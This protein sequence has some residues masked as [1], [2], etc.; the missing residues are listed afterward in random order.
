MAVKLE[1]EALT[2]VALRGH[3]GAEGEEGRRTGTALRCRCTCRRSTARWWTTRRG[4][5]SRPTRSS[6]SC[7]CRLYPDAHD[8]RGRDHR[9]RRA[10]WRDRN[11]ARLGCGGARRWRCGMT[12]YSVTGQGTPRAAARAR[13]TLEIPPSSRCSTRKRRCTTSSTRVGRARGRAGLGRAGERRLARRLARDPA[14]ARG[15]ASGR[16]SRSS[17]ARNFGQHRP[18]SRASI[19]RGRYVITLDADLQN[20]PSEIPRLVAELRNGTTS[21]APCAT[22]ARTRGC[23]SRSRRW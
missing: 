1:V 3:R 23:A 15:G 7:R 12:P 16:W 10:G 20:P 6:A 18:C 14:R 11:A 21:S 8:R 5:R 13:A 4:W 2:G 22:T 19:A 9:G 17:W